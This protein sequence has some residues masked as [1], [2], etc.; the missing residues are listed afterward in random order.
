MG[1]EMCIRDRANR[2]GITWKRN[3]LR[4]SFISYR[5]AIIKNVAQV[6]FEAG[7]SPVMVHRHYLKCVSEAM[8]NKWFALFPEVAPPVVKAE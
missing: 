6:A 2:A 5:V 3:G 8:A 7:N 4:H 1:S